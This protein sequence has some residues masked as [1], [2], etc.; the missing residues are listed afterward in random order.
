MAKTTK[1][2]AAKPAAKKPA[3]K[4]ASPKVSPAKKQAA[5][6]AKKAAPAAKK[7][8]APAKKAAAISKQMSKTEI[9]L[10]IAGN[11]GIARRD[12]SAVMDQLGDLIQRHVNKKAVGSFTLPGLLKIKAVKRPAQ[13]AKKN[14]PHPFKP[15]EFYDV[16]AKPA[17][18]KVKVLPLKKLKDMAAA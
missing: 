18:T 10:E 3:A 11:T 12:V 2:P 15:G 17:S 14:V 6:A 7:P 9:L 13:K 5:P 8:A 1:K 4:K 16:P